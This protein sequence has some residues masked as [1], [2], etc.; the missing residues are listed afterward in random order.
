M[1]LGARPNQVTKPTAPS[2]CVK[3]VCHRT[4]PWL[5][6]FSLDREVVRVR[7]PAG[8]AGDSLWV[9]EESQIKGC[10]HQDNA[11]VHYQPFPESIL[12]EQQV[13]TND[14]GNQHR[15]VKH[16]RHVPRHS[17]SRSN[18]STAALRA[19][20]ASSKR[21]AETGVGSR[22]LTRRCSQHLPGLFPCF[23]MPSNTKLAAMLAFG[24]CG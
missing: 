15:N 3:R 4:L 12:K 21:L 6:S 5:I 18:I 22:D 13:Y 7:Q 2:K 20:N 17:I 9:L 10:K 14:N 1:F 24:R 8:A 19:R 16:D 11:D 23:A